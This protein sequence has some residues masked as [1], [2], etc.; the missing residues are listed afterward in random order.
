[1]I[2]MVPLFVRPV[3]NGEAKAYQV[4][5]EDYMKIDMPLSANPRYNHHLPLTQG[6]IE[7]LNPEVEL[8]ESL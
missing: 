2:L 3:L 8:A 4:L 6:I 5:L 1:M 7:Q